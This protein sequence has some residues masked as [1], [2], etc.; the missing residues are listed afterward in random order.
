MKVMFSNKCRRF[1]LFLFLF[2]GTAV[3]SNIAVGQVV[4]GFNVKEARYSSGVFV[5]QGK[6]KWIEKGASSQNVYKEI[7]R[8]KWSV[9]LTK[10][11]GSKAQIDLYKEKI[12]NAVSGTHTVTRSSTRVGGTNANQIAT[13]GVRNLHFAYN[14]RGS[15]DENMYRFTPPDFKADPN[16]KTIFLIHGFTSKPTQAFGTQG[17]PGLL[18]ALK[19]KYP[20]ATIVTVDWS[21]MSGKKQSDYDWVYRRMWNVGRPLARVLREDLC[22]NP[23]NTILIGHSLGA[24]IAGTAGHE[25]NR[26]TNTKLEQIVGLDAAGVYMSALGSDVRLDKGDAKKVVGIHS[27]EAVHFPSTTQGLGWYKEYGD[28]DIY[29]YTK[30]V[31]SDKKGQLL[32]SGNGNWRNDHSYATTLYTNVIKGNQHRYA[33][34]WTWNEVDF[35]TSFDLTKLDS[36]AGTITVTDVPKRYDLTTS[37]ITTGRRFSEAVDRIT[38]SVRK[39]GSLGRKVGIRLNATRNITWWKAIK[40]FRNGVLEKEI[41]TQDNTKSSK[42]A[43]LNVNDNDLFHIEFCKAKGF[44]VHTPIKKHSI[45]LNS[46]RGSQID[47][48]WSKD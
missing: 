14:G 28:L 36:L 39:D 15:G 18:N 43:K 21:L 12:L 47:F 42:I 24:H 19:T 4:D 33:A 38:A 10:K 7:L 31:A 13:A 16:R 34:K 32:G 3:I 37:N 6:K 2:C 8:D 25:F 30:N 35:R 20:Q 26:L 48:T 5:D 44:G 46:F 45:D 9:Y 17:G 41:W 23:R 22:V 1:A 40:I 11:D 29:I 27:S